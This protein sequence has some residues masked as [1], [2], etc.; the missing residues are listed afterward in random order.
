VRDGAENGVTEN[1]VMRQSTAAHGKAAGVTEG[2]AGGPVGR[3][4]GM[5]SN[6]MARNDDLLRPVRM[7]ELTPAESLELAA[8]VALG[9]VVF[10]HRALPAVRLVNHI[11]ADGHI[12]IR[13]HS[14]AAILGQAGTDGVVAYEADRIDD[15]SHTGWS[16]IVTGT[17]SLVREPDRLTRYQTLLKPWIDTAMT[18]VVRIST[19]IVTGYRLT[20]E[21]PPP[22]PGP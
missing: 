18:H 6:G 12:I 17:A 9:R 3:S 14:G 11:V 15:V 10:S 21:G 5:A 2:G 8:G 22:S 16:V 13:V 20:R 4:N 19:D 7:T 1:D